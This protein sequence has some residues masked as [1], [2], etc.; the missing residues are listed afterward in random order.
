MTL[1]EV[2]KALDGVADVVSRKGEVW[3]ARRGFYWGFDE[4]RANFHAE[5]R[6]ALP[7]ATIVDDGQKFVAFNGGHTVTQGS[8]WWVK[9]TIGGAS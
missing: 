1:S 9:F 3:T 5:I 4:E 7:A 6:K 8:H 2:R